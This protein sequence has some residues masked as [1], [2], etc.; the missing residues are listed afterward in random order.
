MSDPAMVG[1]Y[2]CVDSWD[3]GVYVGVLSAVNGSTVT[4]TNARKLADWHDTPSPMWKIAKTSDT[5]GYKIANSE[6]E[7]TVFEVHRIL[8]CTYYAEDRLKK[9]R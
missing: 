7:I 2:V 3:N 9:Q 6:P 5:W 1:R 8:A 4:I